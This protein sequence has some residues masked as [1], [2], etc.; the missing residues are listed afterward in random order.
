MAAYVVIT[1]DDKQGTVYPDIYG[2]FLT[3]VEA[4]AF[5]KKVDPY[6]LRYIQA[7]GGYYGVHVVSD[8][9]ATPPEEWE[10]G[11]EE[12]EEDALPEVSV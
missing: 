5:A 1:R 8:T 12:D 2:P 7:V 6:E 9:T 11:D 4:E 10:S 3:D